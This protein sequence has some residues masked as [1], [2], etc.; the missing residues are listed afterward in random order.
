MALEFSHKVKT[1]VLVPILGRF[2]GQP[3]VSVRCNFGMNGQD[4]A[5]VCVDLKLLNYIIIALE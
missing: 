1:M 2:D 5:V 4:T 3:G